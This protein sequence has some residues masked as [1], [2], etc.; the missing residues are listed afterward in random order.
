MSGPSELY[1]IVPNELLK[2]FNYLILLYTTLIKLQPLFITG[3]LVK[4]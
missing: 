1:E 2:D 4:R 3:R